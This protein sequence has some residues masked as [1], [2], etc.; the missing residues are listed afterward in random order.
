[1]TQKKITQIEQL[2]NER[3]NASLILSMVANLIIPNNLPEELEDDFPYWFIETILSNKGFIVK[4][5][6][7][8][9]LL[10]GTDLDNGHG[11]DD[12]GT[13]RDFVAFTHMG[14]EYKGELNKD[15]CM[16]RPF[17]SRRPVNTFKK[18]AHDLSEIET[19]RNFLVKW[20]RVAPFFSVRDSKQKTALTEVI[21]SVWGGNMIPFVSD[22]VLSNLV[23]NAKPI[24]VIDVMQS[25]R[26]KDL[27][28]LEQEMESLI[29]HVAEL[30]GLPYTV[31]TKKAQQSISEVESGSGGLCHAIPYD[32]LQNFNRFAK[33]LNKTFGTDISF[34]LSP[35][36]MAEMEKYF[37]QP[38]EDTVGEN[39]QDELNMEENN[40]EPGEDENDNDED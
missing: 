13:G 11:W 27:Q 32:I 2:C 30:F 36:V 20:S 1:M 21:K 18:L 8:Y 39:I 17:S 35:L 29:K 3:S 25:D 28:Y 14:K 33:N 7:G 12:F 10:H 15:G 38:S 23:D 31:S 6:D 9:H 16:V 34:T 24:E 26:V 22:N 4:A 19:S 40:E 5:D 37:E